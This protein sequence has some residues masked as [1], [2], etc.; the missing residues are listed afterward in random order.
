MD[1]VFRH[2]T[3]AMGPGLDGRVG[4]LG[5]AGAMKPIL[6]GLG[7]TSREAAADAKARGEPYALVV[8][9]NPWKEK[10]AEKL[11]YALS[12]TSKPTKI[13]GTGVAIPA[14]SEPVFLV[15]RIMRRLR[16][17]GELKIV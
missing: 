11:A 17:D 15:E 14:G 8:L 2:L 1:L 7:A 5:P 3:S 4:A 9:L 6:M 12:L 13:P 16:L 10:S